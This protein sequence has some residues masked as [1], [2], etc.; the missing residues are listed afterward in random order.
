[1]AT[2]L[3][4]AIGSHTLVVD[5]SMKKQLYFS[6]NSME[7]KDFTQQYLEKFRY[8]DWEDEEEHRDLQIYDFC[9]LMFENPVTADQR[10]IEAF[11][12]YS[13]ANIP[14]FVSESGTVIDIHDAWMSGFHFSQKKW[15]N[16]SELFKNMF[17]DRTFNF[18]RGNGEDDIVPVMGEGSPFETPCYKGGIKHKICGLLVSDCCWCT[19]HQ[20]IIGKENI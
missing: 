16:M 3:K 18:D 15:E 10:F 12:T 5:Q 7:N 11:I 6:K 20:C 9:E 4:L 14:C 19:K 17:N 2:L 1:M 8:E 13:D